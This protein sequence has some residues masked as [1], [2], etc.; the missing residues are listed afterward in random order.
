MVRA[1]SER[2]ENSKNVHI[3]IKSEKIVRIKREE[4]ILEEGRADTLVGIRARSRIAHLLLAHVVE[5]RLNRKQ[6]CAQVKQKLL[7]DYSN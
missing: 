7:R 1:A 3:V 6:R 4:P 2:N 5:Q